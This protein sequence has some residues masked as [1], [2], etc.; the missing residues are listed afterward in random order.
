[1]D[2]KGEPPQQE[3]H[4]IITFKQSTIRQRKFSEVDPRPPIC[5]TNTSSSNTPSSKPDSTPLAGKFHRKLGC[6]ALHTV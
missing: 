5:Y 3:F 2:Q 1:M 6:D 4:V